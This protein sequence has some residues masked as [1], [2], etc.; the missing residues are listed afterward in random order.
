MLRNIL[1]KVEHELASLQEVEDHSTQIWPVQKVIEVLLSPHNRTYGALLTGALKA[2][3]P[4]EN[5][6]ECCTSTTTPIITLRPT[7]TTLTLPPAFPLTTPTITPLAS[8]P[9]LASP[10]LSPV[11]ATP[12]EPLQ[13]LNVDNTVKIDMDTPLTTHSTHSHPYIPHMA[14][15]QALQEE[16]TSTPHPDA[17]RIRMDLVH[18]GTNGLLTFPD[19]STDMDS[20]PTATIIPTPVEESDDSLAILDSSEEYWLNV[21]D[22]AAA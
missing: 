19:H 1:S 17:K 2:P 7:L 6:C 14:E 10:S 9:P 18:Y 12:R 8:S 15:E 13:A 20:L 16:A 22:L 11:S 4:S 3:L 5:C 21:S